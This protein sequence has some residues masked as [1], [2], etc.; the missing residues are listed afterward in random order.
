MVAGYPG[1]SAD[2]VLS[3]APLKVKELRVENGK[4]VV[5]YD[6]GVP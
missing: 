5:V 1:V 6:D 3:T 4:L 2:V